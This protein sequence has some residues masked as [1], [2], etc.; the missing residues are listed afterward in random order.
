MQEKHRTR[1]FVLCVLA[2]AVLLVATIMIMGAAKNQAFDEITVHRIKIVEPDGTVRMVISNHAGFPGVT[3][4]GK[5]IA[6][7]DRPGGGMLFYNDE[8]TENGGLIFAGHQNAKGEIVD[9]GVSLSFD[10]YGANQIVQLAAVSDNENRFAGLR[11]KDASNPGRGSDRIWVGNSED[12]KATVALRDASGR[13]RI[14][15]EV[16]ADGTSS[17]TFLDANGQVVNTLGPTH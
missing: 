12:G 4:K 10:K 1:W 8:G 5:L 11:I 3:E 13:K 9:S 7:N 6:T 15:M 14:V 2:A 16:Q 17:L